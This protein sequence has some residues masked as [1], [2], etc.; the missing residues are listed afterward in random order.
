MKRLI[1]ILSLLL[2][3]LFIPHTTS[4]ATRALFEQTVNVR[5]EPSISSTIIAQVHQG[6]K[7][8][9]IDNQDNWLYVELPNGKKGWVASRFATLTTDSQTEQTIRS[10]VSDLQVRAGPG[11]EHKTIGSISQESEWNVLKIDG[12]WISIDYNGQTGWVASWLV[13]STTLDNSNKS[14]IKKEVITRLLNVREMPGTENRILSQLPSGSVVEEIKTENN[15]SFIRYENGQIGWVDTTYLQNTNKKEET[16]FVTILYHATNLRSGPA[17]SNDV[18]KQASVQERYQIDGKEG[19]WYRIL[20]DDGRSA[21]VADWVVSTASRLT[22]SP[23]LKSAKTVV[24][25]AGH[26]GFDSGALGITTLEKI[27]TLKTTNTIAEKLKNA[28]VEVILTRDDDTF[29]SLAQRTIISE[30]HQADAFVSIHFDSTVDPTANGT[31]TYY[32]EEADMPLASS[33]H[34]EIGDDTSLRDRGIRFG[35][36]YV[37]RNNQQPSVLL[38]LGFLSN[39]WEEQLVNKSTYQ[40]NITNEISN[41]ILAFLQ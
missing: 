5:S 41:G 28:G 12:D 10:T 21:Y 23:K 25:D 30:Q 2:I 7:A 32:Y 40:N 17:L 16:G 20:L 18:I 34:A 39:P 38:E 8:T 35:N 3:A 1:F 19:E 31:T 37:L 13:N 26:G 33:I 22:T 27:L 11:K 24:L 36:Y 15:W 9:I 14:S 4:A 29:I 6:H